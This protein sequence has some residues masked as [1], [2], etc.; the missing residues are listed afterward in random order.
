MKTQIIKILFFFTQNYAAGKFGDI[1]FGKFYVKL[2]K[3]S[4]ALYIYYFKTI[5]KIFTNI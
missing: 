5:Y 1:F 3:I 4:P 2:R